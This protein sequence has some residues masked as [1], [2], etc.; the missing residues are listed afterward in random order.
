MHRGTFTLQSKSSCGF[1]AGRWLHL[2]AFA[3]KFH[4]FSKGFKSGNFARQSIRYISP[5]LSNF[6][7]ATV[8]LW[9]VTLYFNFPRI[10]LLVKVSRCYLCFCLL[11]ISH[12]GIHST[13]LI[14]STVCNRIYR[15]DAVMPEDIYNSIPY[16]TEHYSIF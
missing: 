3:D 13:L 2:L 9:N 6:S 5:L 4:K 7:T 11:Y 12:W 16:H 8:W 15:S 14:R 1:V 10:H